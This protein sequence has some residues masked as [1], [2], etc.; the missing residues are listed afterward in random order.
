MA[1]KK[2]T[3]NQYI[4]VPYNGKNV[5]V[6]IKNRCKVAYANVSNPQISCARTASVLNNRVCT[7]F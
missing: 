2:S 3:H 7:V 6:L 4:Y 5:N 1:Y